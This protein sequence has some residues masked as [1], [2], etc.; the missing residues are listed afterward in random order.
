MEYTQLSFDMCCTVKA[1]EVEILKVR[2]EF[3]NE[4]GE[5]QYHGNPYTQGTT[6][7]CDIYIMYLYITLVYKH[8]TS[9]M[10]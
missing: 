3:P 4:W 8:Y 6:L 9:Y 1:L 7:S 10:T 5:E 2:S